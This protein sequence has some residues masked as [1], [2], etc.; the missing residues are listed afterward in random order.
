MV[1]EFRKLHEK[2][3]NPRI[4]LEPLPGDAIAMSYSDGSG[5]IFDSE[6][7]NVIGELGL[8]FITVHEMAHHIKYLD[9]NDIFGYDSEL[10]ANSLSLYFL[11]FSALP[12]EVIDFLDNYEF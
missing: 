7:I 11:Q 10:F 8:K 2:L 1:D 6:K 9:V 5:I 12:K 4:D 3:P